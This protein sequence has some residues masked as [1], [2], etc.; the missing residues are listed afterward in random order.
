M[1]LKQTCPRHP[2]YSLPAVNTHQ[3]CVFDRATIV[4]AFCGIKIVKFILLFVLQLGPSLPV[5]VQSDQLCHEVFSTDSY[6]N[7]WINRVMTV[8][9][10]KVLKSY[11]GLFLFSSIND[12]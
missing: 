5:I 1:L 8:S 6:R 3:N 9:L 11:L 2:A 4:L 12:E 10:A 7:T